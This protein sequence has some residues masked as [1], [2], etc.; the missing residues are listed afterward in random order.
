MRPE[1]KDAFV[2]SQEDLDGMLELLEDERLN[3][4]DMHY[5]LDIE[6]INPVALLNK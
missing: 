4:F 5:A 3:D 2:P 1:P 6:S